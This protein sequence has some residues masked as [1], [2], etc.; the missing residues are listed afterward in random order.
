MRIANA[1]L[2]CGLVAALGCL[3]YAG[4]CSQSA[5][6]P[7][8]VSPAATLKDV[9]M[10]KV[11]VFDEQGQLQ[12]PV[13]SP[14]LVLSDEQWRQRLTAEQFEVLR[15]KG[16]ER[17]YCGT[18]LDNK[19]TGVYACSGCGL[20]LFSSDAKFT[21]GTGWPSFFQP[22]APG[23]VLE[24]SDQSYGM[25][26]TE[27]TCAR[28]EGHLGHVFDDGPRPTG[29]RFCLNSASLEFTPNDQLSKLADPLAKK[30]S[31]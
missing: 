6:R 25:T 22:V 27:I 14:K 12:G 29:L 13:E 4:G 30:A 16:T 19:Q 5:Q 20:P 28:C 21:S 17:P 23:N 2:T 18:L 3:L 7:A 8:P 15:S 31:P 10:V 24:E 26:R 11:Y 9:P 1:D